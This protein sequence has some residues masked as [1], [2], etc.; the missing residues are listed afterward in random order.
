MTLYNFSS[1]DLKKD[2]RHLCQRGS[3]SSMFTMPCFDSKVTTNIH[4]YM[5]LNVGKEVNV[6]F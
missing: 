3:K 6:Q 1:K 5:A 2:T 4:G